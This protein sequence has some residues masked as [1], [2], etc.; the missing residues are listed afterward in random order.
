[1]TSSTCSGREAPH[2]DNDDDAATPEDASS[3]IC[4][5]ARTFAVRCLAIFKC[6]FLSLVRGK[7]FICL[8][9]IDA[10]A[11]TAL[12]DSNRNLSSAM[13]T[14]DTTTTVL[15]T[16]KGLLR[17]HLLTSQERSDQ[18]TGSS[19]LLGQHGIASDQLVLVYSLELNAFNKSKL[20]RCD[21]YNRIRF[22]L[23]PSLYGRPV[24]LFTNYCNDYTQFNR[25]SF[26]L[27]TRLIVMFSNMIF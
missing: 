13:E 14:P 16:M 5:A 1:M 9:D 26:T 7:K 24:A 25:Y 12:A 23:A 6:V 18:E 22:H 11:L 21:K 27:N 15:P 3:W 17:S 19:S 2:A 8:P 20:F 10:E 4:T